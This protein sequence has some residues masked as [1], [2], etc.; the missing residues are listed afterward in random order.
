MGCRTSF[1][2]SVSGFAF[3]RY[4]VVHL[5]ARSRREPREERPRH[6]PAP[7]EALGAGVRQ[8][9]PQRFDRRWVDP[10]P[11]QHGVDLPDDLL[12]AR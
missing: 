12:D 9:A 3:A 1:R 11:R 5:P 8:R 10:P 4:L 2:R 7:P 6:G